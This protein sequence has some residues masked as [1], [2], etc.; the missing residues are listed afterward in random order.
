MR[1]V[2]KNIIIF[3]Q[4]KMLT[5]KSRSGDIYSYQSI[6]GVAIGSYMAQRQQNNRRKS[7][8]E[9]GKS[10]YIHADEV[11]HQIIQKIIELRTQG[12]TWSQI[13]HQLKFTEYL[14]KNVYSKHTNT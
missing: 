5:V 13:A 4:H 7:R 6:N 14:V 11:P 8:L 10:Q 3:G 2:Q 12:S 9:H 1:F